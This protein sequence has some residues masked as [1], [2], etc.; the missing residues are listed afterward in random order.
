LL[1]GKNHSLSPFLTVS[2][3][4]ERLR[5]KGGP[6]HARSEDPGVLTGQDA[7]KPIEAY[8]DDASEARRRHEFAPI[9]AV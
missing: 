9:N 6:L 3:L 1:L 8:V 7:L 4:Y 5:G 2:L